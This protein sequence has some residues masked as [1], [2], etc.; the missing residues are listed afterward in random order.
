MAGQGQLVATA[1]RVTVDQRDEWFATRLQP[2]VHGDRC[3]FTQGQ[4]RRGRLRTAHQTQNVVKIGT[5]HKRRLRRANDRAN[6]GRVTGY[7]LDRR[8]QIGNECG[9]YDIDAMPDSIERNDGNARGIQL[10]TECLRHRVRL[11]L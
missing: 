5:R 1:E 8:N 4:R 9:R 7:L 10:I 2:S 3:S 11:A 6:D